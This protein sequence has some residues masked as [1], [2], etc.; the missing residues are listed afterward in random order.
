[1]SRSRISR[2][3]IGDLNVR[4]VAAPDGAPLGWAICALTQDVSNAHQAD[5]LILRQCADYW[6][7]ETAERGLR[8]RLWKARRRIAKLAQPSEVWE[9]NALPELRSAD[10][11]WTVLESDE[12]A[13]FR[14]G[15]HHIV[16]AREK[17]H[18]PQKDLLAEYC[19][20]HPEYASSEDKIRR[21]LKEA[22]IDPHGSNSTD[23]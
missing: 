5:L 13:A 6:E 7:A 21:L 4:P 15:Q 19:E 16:C 1:M 3:V 8:H 22:M 2:E 23:R 10:M 9:W 12:L 17:W 18:P 14:N 11:E 20:R